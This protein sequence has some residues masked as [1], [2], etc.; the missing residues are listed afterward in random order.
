[1]MSPSPPANEKGSPAS[2]LPSARPY[3]FLIVV[4]PLAALVTIVPHQLLW[5]SDKHAGWVERE[6]FAFPGDPPRWVIVLGLALSLGLHELLHAVGYAVFGRVPWRQIEFGVRWSQ[7]IVY[8][9]SR[10]PVARPA[11]C[12]A[13]ML[14]TIVLGVVPAVVGLSLGIG[15]M[16][17][18]GFFLVV[19]A[20]GDFINLWGI[21]RLGRAQKK[22]PG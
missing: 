6:L 5:G 2:Q 17:L 12:K 9:R 19:L 1:M 10:V 22:A 15:W 4:A 20:T 21:L 3:L 11:Y 18:Y 14:P 13:L 8:A 7:L 16:T